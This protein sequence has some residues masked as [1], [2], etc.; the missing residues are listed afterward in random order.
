[1]YILSPDMSLT[2]LHRVFFRV[3]LAGSPFVLVEAT[4]FLLVLAAVGFFALK[5]NRIQFQVM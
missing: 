2:S 1:M 3:F 4:A 5:K